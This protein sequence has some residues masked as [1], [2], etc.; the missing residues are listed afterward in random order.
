M[1][2]ST[3][4]NTFS[5]LGVHGV[6]RQKL[7]FNHMKV[8]VCVLC[9]MLLEESSRGRTT[10]LH[11]WS[12]QQRRELSFLLK[13]RSQQKGGQLM[14]C[15]QNAARPLLWIFMHIFMQMILLSFWRTYL[16]LCKRNNKSKMCVDP[17]TCL[18]YASF[19][20]RLLTSWSCVC[21]HVDLGSI[22]PPFMNKLHCHH[23]YYDY[24]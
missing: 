23:C 11:T 10:E 20:M 7:L 1:R 16:S 2:I 14:T 9:C 17:T 19:F 15:G 12:K 5:F 13:L 22:F 24:N 21:K 6:W 18:L 4:F 3:I 8:I